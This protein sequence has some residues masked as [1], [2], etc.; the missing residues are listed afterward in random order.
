MIRVS[1]GARRPS[2]SRNH[3]RTKQYEDDHRRG[4]RSAGI[5]ELLG[6]GHGGPKHADASRMKC[7]VLAVV[8][9]GFW[10]RWAGEAVCD[11]V[12]DSRRPGHM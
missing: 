4:L 5:S 10:S 2:D 11:T 9:W 3:R 6:M 1:G 12:E 7:R 8:L